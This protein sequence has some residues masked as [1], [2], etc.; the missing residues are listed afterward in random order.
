MWADQTLLTPAFCISALLVTSLLHPNL[1]DSSSSGSQIAGSQLAGFQRYWQPGCWIPSCW[2]PTALAVRLLDLACP[3]KIP[4]AGFSVTKLALGA[5]IF[6]G[7]H[8]GIGHAPERVTETRTGRNK[9]MHGP[10]NKAAPLGK[11]LPVQS[12]FQV[13]S[14]HAVDEKNHDQLEGASVQGDFFLSVA[15]LL[16]TFRCGGCLLSCFSCC[17][18]CYPLLATSCLAFS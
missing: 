18:P 17:H 12:L 10:A 11:G 7:K 15:A 16:L 1:L 8:W 3:K 13:A 5:D 4:Q 14:G 2:V 9:H 6:G